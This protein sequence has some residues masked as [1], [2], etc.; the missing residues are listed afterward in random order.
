MRRL[1]PLPIEAIVRGY[2]AGSGWKDYQKNQMICGIAL[3][4]GLKEAQQLPR[5][6]FT[7]STKAA[8]GK[9][10]ENIRSRRWRS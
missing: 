6:I 2:M 7:P 10:D 5:P 1:Q 4:A 3:P 8:I 9:H